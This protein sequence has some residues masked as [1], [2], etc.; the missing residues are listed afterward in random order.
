VPKPAALLQAAGAWL[1]THPDSSVVALNLT[2]FDMLGRN[3][4]GGR[5]LLDLVVDQGARRV[6]P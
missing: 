1:A 2:N 3:P 4:H 5:F 6:D